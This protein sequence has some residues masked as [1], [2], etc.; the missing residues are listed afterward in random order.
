MFVAAGW[1]ANASFG[2][3]MV[4]EV[5]ASTPPPTYVE[6]ALMAHRTTM[7][8][9]SM[10]SQPEVPDYDSGRRAATAIVMPGLPEGWRVTDVQ[11]FPSKFGPSVEMALYT[12]G[13]SSS[14][15]HSFRKIESA[16][17][18]CAASR[19]HAPGAI[20]SAAGCGL[21]STLPS[22]RNPL[23]RRGTGRDRDR[24]RRRPQ[25]LCA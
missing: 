11:L 9:A 21:Y 19:I 16:S 13:K 1:F 20:A 3:L 23:I 6:D 7:V 2:P 10:A 25:L 15:P 8:R 24:P 12:C 22:D 5:V 4:S 14:T 18:H 17:W